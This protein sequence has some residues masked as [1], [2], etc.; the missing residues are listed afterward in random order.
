MDDTPP[1]IT[2]TEYFV[3]PPGVYRQYTHKERNRM[4]FSLLLIEKWQERS[5]SQPF[6]HRHWRHRSY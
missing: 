5:I 4:Y 6:D 1:R 2:L 3:H